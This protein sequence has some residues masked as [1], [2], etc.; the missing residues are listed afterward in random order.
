MADD[1]EFDQFWQAYPRR[2]AKGDARKAWHQTARL[3]PG[4]Q[5]LLKALAI[6]RASNQWQKDGGQY[7]PY[8]ATWLRGERW[9]DVH[10][11]DLARSSTDKPWWQ[12]ASGIEARGREL[13]LIWGDTEGETFQAY[14]RRVR[15]ASERSK[16][17]YLT[18][19][20]KQA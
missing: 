13:G 10:E 16:V 7:I 3:R 6:A 8:P 4:S 2:I 1:P 9:A 5:D 12:S 14:A 20:A 17:H 19:G 18:P 11:I 15:A